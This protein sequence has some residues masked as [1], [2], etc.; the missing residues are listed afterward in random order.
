MITKGIK[1]KRLIIEKADRE[2]V[3]AKLAELRLTVHEDVCDD[4]DMALLEVDTLPE[5]IDDVIGLIK[6]LDD[7]FDPAV[8]TKPSLVPDL[9]AVLGFPQHKGVKA[10]ADTPETFEIPDSGAG[11]G[12]RVGI[13]DT[14]ILPH[15]L[16]PPD[17]VHRD[18]EVLPESVTEDLENMAGHGTFV[19]GLIRRAAPGAVLHVRAGLNTWLEYTSTWEVAKAIASFQHV[20]IDILNLAL[21]CTTDTG[22]PPAVISRALDKIPSTVMVIAAAGNREL[23]P[24]PSG[25]IWPGAMDRVIAVGDPDANYSMHKEWV[26]YVVDGVDQVST[27]RDN[28][29]KSWSGTSFSA[30][31]LTGMVAAR[32]GDGLSA[33][34]ALAFLVTHGLV[35]RYGRDA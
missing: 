23:Q 28:G 15:R 26:D 31:K 22:K 16:L 24:V 13:V 29:F 27:H 32:M 3:T 19:A 7:M 6:R 20:E 9:D 1:Q 17:I 2:R 18:K 10:P 8:E 35:K 21:G 30:A 4:L 25:Q 14:A 5:G 34:D 11:A 12:V 33:D